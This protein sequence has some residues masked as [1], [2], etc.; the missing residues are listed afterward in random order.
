MQ[1][2][3]LSDCKKNLLETSWEAAACQSC[4]WVHPHALKRIS[5]TSIGCVNITEDCTGYVVLEEKELILLDQL[6]EADKTG[7]TGKTGKRV[8]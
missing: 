3:P 6:F 5:S 1:V 7:T 2:Q 8:V 4:S